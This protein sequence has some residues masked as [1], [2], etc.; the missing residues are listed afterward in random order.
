MRPAGLLGLP[1]VRACCSDLLCRGL[2]GVPLLS[3]MARVV[4][5]VVN[6]VAG[7]YGRAAGG[8]AVHAALE[9]SK[10]PLSGFLLL[11]MGKALS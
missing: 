8:W 9:L 4:G 1:L 11:L 7:C 6:P 5:I 10:V 2:S 3:G